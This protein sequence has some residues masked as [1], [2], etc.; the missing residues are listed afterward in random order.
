MQDWS[1]AKKRI[2]KCSESDWCSDLFF[3]S[4][5]KNYR[6]S[7]LAS[8]LQIVP[9]A[10]LSEYT[11]A[12]SS[13][14][15]PLFSQTGSPK[16]CNRK[17]PTVLCRNIPSNAC[18]STMTGDLVTKIIKKKGF[19]LSFQVQAEESGLRLSSSITP[20][21]SI[22]LYP[23][24]WGFWRHG[25]TNVCPSDTTSLRA[26]NHVHRGVPRFTGKVVQ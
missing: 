9:I 23:V 1:E 25:P 15:R 2:L 5:Q 19:L 4:G 16:W 22:Q 7:S 24:R 11:S 10:T 13:H 3:I 21:K 8:T 20:L 18:L 12:K 17:G 6:E 26:V 14:I